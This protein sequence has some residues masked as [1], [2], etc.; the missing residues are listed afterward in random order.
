MTDK[1]GWIDNLRAV[2]CMMVVLIHST[3]Y[4]ITAGGA[5]GDV[6]WD[7]ANILNS[8]SRVCVPLFFM[9]SGYLFLASAAPGGNILR[10]L[11]YAFCSIALSL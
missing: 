10:A 5:P 4:Y 9:I 3:T 6:H 2:A 1:I 11:V 8:A 7:V